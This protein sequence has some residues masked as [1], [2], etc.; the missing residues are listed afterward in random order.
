[1]TIYDY[2]YSLDYLI[3]EILY[4]ENSKSY[5]ELKRRLESYST[6]RKAISFDTYNRH[7]NSLSNH[8]ILEKKKI[9]NKVFLSLNQ[10]YRRKLDSGHLTDEDKHFQDKRNIPI[11]AKMFVGT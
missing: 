10:S 7:I 1:M 2:K 3:I 6:S 8:K 11:S 5:R 9:R 4:H